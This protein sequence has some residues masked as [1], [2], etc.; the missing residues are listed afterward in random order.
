MP[1]QAVHSILSND[2]FKK[3]IPDEA[4]IDELFKMI[5]N[6]AKGT[7]VDVEEKARL[8]ARPSSKVRACRMLRTVNFPP[9]GNLRDN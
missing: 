5:E 3:A 6:G 4:Q 1:V 8:P 2:I 9:R 7:L